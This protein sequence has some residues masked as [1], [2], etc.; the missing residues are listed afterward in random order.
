MRKL[1]TV[2]VFL[3]AMGLQAQ[4]LTCTITVNSDQ[5]TNGDL[6]IFKTLEKSLN[7]FVNKTKWTNRTFKDNERVNAQMF[8][9]ITNYQSNRF[10]GT[11]QIQSSR[12]VYNTSRW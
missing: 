3:L 4:E 5:L 9:N 7:D 11:L 10:Q 2:V 1:I 6:P 8:I 12:P